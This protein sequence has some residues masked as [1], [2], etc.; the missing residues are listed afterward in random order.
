LTLRTLE[1]GTWLD[2]VTTHIVQDPINPDCKNSTF[3][4]SHSPQRYCC[5]QPKPKITEQSSKPFI[6]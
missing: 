6:S 2:R 1:I 3:L 5:L 4:V